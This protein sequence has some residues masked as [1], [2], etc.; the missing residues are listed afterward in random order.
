MGRFQRNVL[1]HAGATALGSFVQLVLILALSHW[2]EVEVFASFLTAVAVVGFG[3]MASD[4]GV[5]VW[6]VQQFALGKGV[7]RILG[8]TLLIKAGYSMLMVVLVMVLPLSLLDWR[9]ALLTVLIASAQPSTDPLLWFLRGK[10][11]LD[12][13]AA[14]VLT[15]RI[16]NAALLAGLAL[17]GFGVTALLL[18]WLL[19]NL[20]RGL[21]TWV[22]PWLAPLRKVSSWTKEGMVREAWLVARLAFPIGAAF[23]AMAV[24]QRL[25]VLMLGELAQPQVVA[26]YGAAFTLVASAGFVATSITVSSFPALS[27]AAEAGAWDEASKIVYRKLRWVMF[28]FLPGCIMGAFLAPY[29]IG[30][31][32]PPSY[33]PA[34]AVMVALLPGLYISTIN[35]ALKFVLNAL[36][37]NWA[38]VTSV[39]LGIAFFTIVLLNATSKDMLRLVGFAWSLGEAFIFMAKWWFL[40][41][42]GR[43]V[44]LALGWH[45]LVFIALM[46]ALLPW[47]LGL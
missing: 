36:H 3:E 21:T 11:R 37:L 4:F 45:V 23:I 43:I 8:P 34:A 29:V 31:L 40:R 10:E 18:A 12:V 20:A 1:S 30:L 35:L 19:S 9:Q 46:L 28:V 2:L 14:V 22:L 6:A 44:S 32:Y 41:R 47:D 33:A 25:G 17:M 39:A 27:R 5:R 13:E 26:W 15:W 38:D 16:G 24:Y 7:Q 42:D